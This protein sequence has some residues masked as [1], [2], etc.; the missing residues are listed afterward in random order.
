MANPQ[1]NFL[2]DYL[3]KV[4]QD[5]GKADLVQ[6]GDDDND[7]YSTV[8]DDD[9]NTGDEFDYQLS[10]D[11]D[12]Q[13]DQMQMQEN[14]SGDENYL[15]QLM[16]DQD[17]Y[18]GVGFGD[19]QESD[20]ESEGDD[21]SFIGPSG[22][23]TGGSGNDGDVSRKIANQESDGGKYSAYNNKGGGSGAVGKYQFRWNIWKDS[24]QKVT[25]VKS[26]EEFMKSPQAQEKYFA[27]YERTYLRPGAAKLQKYNKKNLDNDQL[28]QLIHFRGLGGAKKYLQG[29]LADKPES[30]NTPISKYIAKKQAGGPVVA[31]NQAAQYN[32]L[33]NPSF[34]QMVFPMRGVN[35]FRGLDNGEPV[36][37]EDE[38]GKKKVLK[39]KKHKTRMTGTVYEKRLNK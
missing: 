5:S 8:S 6:I 3:N 9:Q 34:N 37:L 27:W 36:Y 7:F 33:N 10:N 1:Y 35:E 16:G 29:K 15:D 38:T 4:A 23:P 31:A 18:S 28:E 20:D 26:K 24:I 14:E 30:Y 32:G 13:Q 12:D 17:P 39:G 21:D 11:E 19:D 22:T 2:N 25:G